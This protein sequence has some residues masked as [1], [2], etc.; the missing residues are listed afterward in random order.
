MNQASFNPNE[1][2]VPNGCFF[3]FPYSVEEAAI[4]I[5]PVPWD[6]TTSYRE[7]TVNGPQAILDASLQLDW[8]D[9]DLPQ[10]WQTKCGTIP[11]NSDIQDK[12][13]AM[14]AIAKEIIGDMETG[15]NVDDDAIAK[16]LVTVNQASATLNHWVYTQ[17]LELL[18]QGKLVGVVGGDHSVPLGLMQA[19][20]Q[21][22]ETY[23]ILQIDAHADLRLAY[24]GFTYSHASIMHN[25][26]SIPQISRLV[27]VGIRDV[28]EA[29]MAMVN[30]DSRI[31]MFDDWK[32]KANAYEG[33]TW[34]AQCDKIIS[35]LPD[36]VYIS[37]DIDGLNPSY[38]PHT[39][40]PVPGGLEFNEAIYLLRLLVKT[41][42]TIIGFDLCE[43][44]PGNVGDEWDGNVGARVLYKLACLQGVQISC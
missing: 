22:H 16:Q 3:G 30:S 20:A 7:A 12:N 26:L 44:A 19:L 35:N 17:A 33:I 15:G 2:T 32:L 43:V 27:Q 8:Y 4:V 21:K 9:F 10:A 36:K 18:E 5:L 24:E 37:F 38:C 42:K 28:C 39:G 1:I 31:V 25:A 6:V 29:E 13:R 23:G 41:G 14:R 34:A 40:T 11:I